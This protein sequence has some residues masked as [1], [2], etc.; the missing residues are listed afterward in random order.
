MNNIEKLNKLLED[1]LNKEE[2]ADI[3]KETTIIIDYRELFKDYSEK[4]YKATYKTRGGDII[5]TYIPK[6]IVDKDGNIPLWFTGKQTGFPVFT[7]WADYLKDYFK[8]LKRI[9]ENKKIVETE[10]DEELKEKALRRLNN[11]SKHKEKTA[12]VLDMILRLTAERFIIK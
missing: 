10:E 12:K 7:V 2:V 1:N 3:N 5:T 8:I 9:A 11:L 4:A 6:S